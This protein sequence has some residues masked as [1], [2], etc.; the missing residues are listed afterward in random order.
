MNRRRCG[1]ADPRPPDLRA[2]LD[3][4]RAASLAMLGPALEEPERFQV[5][6]VDWLTRRAD[7]TTVVCDPHR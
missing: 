3:L 4:V 6:V 2:R 5:V 1:P 7:G